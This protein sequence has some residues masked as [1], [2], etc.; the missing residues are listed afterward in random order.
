MKLVNE[1][2]DDATNFEKLAANETNLEFRNQL[3]QQARAYRKLAEERA[4]QLG[5]ALP[6]ERAKPDVKVG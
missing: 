2:L 1:Y 6:N 5:V 4:K 3:L